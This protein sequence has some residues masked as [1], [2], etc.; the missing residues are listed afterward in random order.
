MDKEIKSVTILGK[1]GSGRDCPFDTEEVWGVNN[2][3]EHPDFRGALSSIKLV[4]KGSGYTSPPAV[5]FEGDGSGIQAQ[6]F[7][8]GDQ[9]CRIDVFDPGSGYSCPP[10]V[11]L[12]GGGGSGALAEV[13][14]SPKRKID[15]LFAFDEALEQGY[16]DG[17]KRFAPIMSWQKYAD[18][19]FPL[20]EVIARFG[21][22]YFTNTVSYML[23][24]AIFLKIPIIK[25]YGVDTSFG[26]PYAQE[27][28]GVEYWLGRA[29]EGG[30][31]VI[32][33]PESHLLRTISG[34]I[35]GDLDHCNMMLH[36]NERINL[37]NILPREGS[38]SDVLKA[39]NAWWVLFP[40]EDE[41]KAH[42]V[43]VQKLPD[44]SLNFQCA[45][46]YLSD[47]HM[48]PE[49]WQFLRDLLVKMEKTGHLPFAAITAYEKLILAKP[50]GGN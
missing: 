29:E 41:A 23:A 35:Y 24:Y 33:H 47:V 9:V 15:K 17:M 8:E 36:L 46:E 11:T 21:T 32:N 2:V 40:K 28:R 42:N 43:Q 14:V 25:I 37:I 27:N 10:V 18:I 44:G 1:S 3:A 31:T 12:S 5:S 45:T 48:P 49:T 16:T 20:E 6:A 4:A 22:R 50:P 7:L 19:P 26:A 38:Y 39:Q 13:K 34:A 30:V